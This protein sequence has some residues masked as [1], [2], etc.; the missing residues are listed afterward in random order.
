MSYEKLCNTPSDIHEHLPTL[1]F[2]AEGLDHVT[3]MG[4]RNVVSTWAFIEAQPKV[5]RCYDINSAPIY[6]VTQKAGEY[7][8]DFKFICADVLKVKIE[9][10]DLLF[11]DTLHQYTQLKAE[12]ELHEKKVRKYLIFHD[13]TTYADIP[14]PLKEQTENIWDNYTQ[15]DQGIWLAIQELID[16]GDWDIL[17]KYENNNGLT[18]LGRI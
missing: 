13:T 4:V 5:L 11:I 14:E 9:T 17:V 7:G 2:Y 16:K 6:E 3:E 8:I 18:V 12:L 1:K 15:D 10:T